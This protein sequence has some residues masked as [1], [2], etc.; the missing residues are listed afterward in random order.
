MRSGRACGLALAAVAL[1]TC[2]PGAR[3]RR[4]APEAAP[5][6]LLPDPDTDLSPARAELGGVDGRTVAD[7]DTCGGCHQDVFAQQQASAHAFSSFNNPVYRVA[8]DRV[9]EEA[10]ARPSRMCGGCHDIALLADGVMD[11]EVAPE[12][13]RGH[14]GVTCRVC[15][16]IDQATVDGN[17]SY[18]VTRPIALPREDDPASIAAHKASVRPL[19]TAEMCGSCHR[20]FLDDATGNHGV[21]L[22]GQDDLTAWQ[23]S[24]YNHSGLGRIDDPIAKQDCIA[25]HMPREAATRGDA[26]AKGGTVASHRFPGGHTWLAAMLGDAD[27]LARQRE[28][29]AGAVSIDLVELRDQGAGRRA[30]DAGAPLAAGQTVWLDAVVRNL[31]VGHRF[32]A[33][34]LDAQDSWIELEVATA[35]GRPLARAGWDQAARGEDP[36]AHLFRSL[37]ADEDGRLRFE[38][39]THAFRAP[40]VNHT[41]APRDAVAVR[42]RFQVPDRLRA[43][44]FP[45]AV[46]A[47]VVHRS[48]N[49]PLQRAACAAARSARGQR[50]A[51]TARQLDQRV[52]DPCPSQPITM[53]AETRAQ[54]GPG[55]APRDDWRR[56]YLHGMALLQARQEHLEEARAPLQ[57]ALALVERDRRAGARERAMVLLQLGRLEGLQGRADAAC[58]RLD[59]AE[60][61]V[62]GHPAI[63]YARGAALSRVWR[64]QE[65]AEAFQAATGAARDNAH[66]WAQLAMALASVG[67]EGEALAAARRGL[68]L[69]PRHAD[70]LRVQALALAALGLPE[71][72]SGAALEAYD[73]YR[74]PDRTTDLRFECAARDP[75]CALER[76]PV[77]V[78][79]LIP[80]RP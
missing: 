44:D 21:F 13:A 68:A 76:D 30:P 71:A 57:S 63:A 78:H 42:Y 54:L 36:S 8:V 25:C 43:G 28:F 58:E 41:I 5:S 23:G 56:S 9:R 73:R 46:T 32:P 72:E 15:H 59:Q 12:D 64:W 6:A 34:V 33:G 17:G 14:A 50:F 70:C 1:A 52:L 45:L 66:G 74:P 29:L 61:L 53:V 60:A 11:G 18:A 19:R 35:G 77:H 22:T 65:A 67:R 75:R 62:P 80:V 40:I 37:V 26:A 20:S 69:E 31:R 55:A 38:R 49:L 16:G 79:P 27:Q 2:G 39:E 47:R 4:A 3:E 10:G 24:A 51:A 7:V 48:R